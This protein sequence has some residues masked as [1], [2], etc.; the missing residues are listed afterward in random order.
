MIE[1]IE[2]FRTDHARIFRYPLLTKIENL[3]LLT[4]V[5]LGFYFLSFIA[6]DKIYWLVLVSDWSLNALLVTIAVVFASMRLKIVCIYTARYILR[7]TSENLRL[8]FLAWLPASW[9]MFKV[10]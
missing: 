6:A 8:L 10:L 2:L 1:L 5:C 3:I 4:F 9:R 7:P